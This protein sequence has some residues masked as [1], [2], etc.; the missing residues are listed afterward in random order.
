VVVSGTLGLMPNKRLL[1]RPAERQR[2][3]HSK[4]QPQSHQ[5]QHLPQDERK[6]MALVVVGGV[7]RTLPR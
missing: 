7:P 3:R 2:R 1:V 4:H 5:G 6:V